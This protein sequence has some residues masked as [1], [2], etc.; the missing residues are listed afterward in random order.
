M[1]KVTDAVIA[2]LK[3]K[4]ETGDIP[5]GPDFS[6]F[7]EAVQEAAQDHEHNAEGGSGS[8]TGN[9][10]KVAWATG[11]S[12]I[13]GTFPPSSH[14][15]DTRYF[16]E[17]EHIN[18]SAGAG[19]AGKPIKLNAE[20]KVDPTMVNG[21]GGGVTFCDTEVFSGPAPYWANGAPQDLDLSSI[22]G[23]NHALV[24]LRIKHSGGAGHGYYFRE[25]GFSEVVGAGC[26]NAGGTTV[27]KLNPGNIVYLWLKTSAVGKVNWGADEDYATTIHL[28]AY[29]T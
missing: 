25:A 11:L 22:V 8:G 12:G 21:G 20:G 9:A 2:A 3:A 19:D 24:M 5:D 29:I 4:F 13:P 6:E 10:S 15:H 7:I 14:N 17:D 18:E 1:S 28:V 27:A 16:T 23:E 26:I